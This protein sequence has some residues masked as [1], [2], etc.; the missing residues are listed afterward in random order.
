M[1]FEG[2]FQLF[3]TIVK[4][5]TSLLIGSITLLAGS[6]YVYQNKIIYA[7]SVPA[8]ARILVD[9]PSKYGLDFEEITLLTPDD[10]KL[11]CYLIMQDAS[12]APQRPTVM[13]YHANA[14]NVLT[15][16]F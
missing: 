4:W 2:S 13:L 15:T 6:L 16:Q 14:G 11:H 10:E 8:G 5:T 3:M 7:S 12:I 1:G 9:T